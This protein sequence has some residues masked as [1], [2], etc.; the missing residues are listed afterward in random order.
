MKIASI[1]IVSIC[2]RLCK[3][4]KNI[5]GGGKK[6]ALKTK[7]PIF[8]T[9][10]DKQSS[11]RYNYQLS[12][13]AEFSQ[14]F[15]ADTGVLP[16]YDKNVKMYYTLDFAYFPVTCD[17][18]EYFSKRIKSPER[19]LIRKAI[20][21]GFTCGEINYDDY[22]DDIS[23]INNSKASRQGKSMSEDYVG[24]LPPRQKI[25]SQ[26]GQN[27]HCFGC[28]NAEGKL[29]A[30]YMFEGYG[31]EILHT[32]KGIGHSEFLNYGIMN[33]LFAFSI[34]E[35][36]K[37]Y[38]KG[39]KVILYGGMN[40]SGGGLNRFKRNV[41]CLQGSPT[42]KGTKEFFSDLKSV[43]KRFKIHGDT[44]L[45]YVLDYVQNK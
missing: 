8:I 28:F 3:R 34:G 39:D 38:P 41:G 37:K 33:F 4:L 27:V 7:T 44:G 1:T 25:I 6:Y 32:V 29:I 23:E 24:K 20:K 40:L 45:N 31:Q 18:D 11:V 22:L 16:G 15:K 14:Y 9:P 26:I 17:Y 12:F 43:N 30:Y 13:F 42:I 5:I 2:K 19:A 35:L 21:N 36:F 10:I